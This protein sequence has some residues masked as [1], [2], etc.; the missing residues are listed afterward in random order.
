[1]EKIIFLQINTGHLNLKMA[2]KKE[3][4]KNRLKTSAPVYLPAFVSLC[5]LDWLLEELSNQRPSSKTLLT[6]SD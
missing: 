6:V 3:P 2:Q 4:F 5:V 1:M